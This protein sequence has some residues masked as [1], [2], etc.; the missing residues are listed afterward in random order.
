MARPA[1]GHSAGRPSKTIAQFCRDYQICR[2]TFEN[3]E[4]LGKAPAIFQ[5]IPGGRKLITDVAETDWK[6]RNAGL[7]SEPAKSSNP[8]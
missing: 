4:K 1:T 5:P 2:T 3:W 8:Q 7:E 6:R